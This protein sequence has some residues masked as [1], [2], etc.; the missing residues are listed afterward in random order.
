M[1]AYFEAR[2]L[3]ADLPC[4]KKDEPDV[5]ALCQALVT[6]SAAQRTDVDQDLQDIYELA[7]EEG[8]R[9]L[10]EEAR[11]RGEDLTGILTELEG[12]YDAAMW[13]LLHREELFA[14]ILRFRGADTLNSRYWRRRRGIPEAH[15]D[16]SRAALSLL[17]TSIT[18][19]LLQKEGR[20]HHCHVE[21]VR[22]STGFLFIAYPEDYGQTMLEYDEDKLVRRKYR[23]ATDLLFFFSSD[24]STLEVFCQGTKDR[25][26]DLQEIF[27]RSILGIELGP[28]AGAEKAYRLNLLKEESFSFV[29]DPT[30]GLEGIEVKWVTLRDRDG[31][32]QMILQVGGPAGRGLIFAAQK[33][34]A[35][36]PDD[37][38]TRYPLDLM[39][40]YRAKLQ[41][42]F[43]PL[44]KRRWGRS[45]TFTLS[46]NGCLLD[47]EGPDGVIREALVASGLEHPAPELVSA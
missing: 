2:K 22:R 1:R 4:L 23:P 8:M 20:G 28:D 36:R 35:T 45:R 41:A 44:G 42:V 38:T 14:D 43:R 18:S 17:S 40:V 31:G 15:P 47:H 34:F 25:V 19:Y 7:D 9:L 16:T 26:R 11:F 21:W 29:F 12:P 27:A 39:D 46:P 10:Y 24:R 13:A 30:S 5:E 32:R 3:L 6:L 33:Y 37:E